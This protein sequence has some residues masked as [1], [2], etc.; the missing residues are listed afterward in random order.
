MKSEPISHNWSKLNHSSLFSSY[1]MPLLRLYIF[2][3]LACFITSALAA[4]NES[5]YEEDYYESLLIQE[6]RSFRQI[7]MQARKEK[8]VILIEFS[9][10]WCEYCEAL[11]QQVLEPLILS[12]QYHDSVIIRKLEINDYSSVI[13]FDDKKYETEEVAMQY[14]INLYPTLVFFDANGNEISHRI[15]GIR[16]LDYIGEEIDKAIEKAIGTI[17][18]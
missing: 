7:A 9:T 1:N 8:K 18:K 11:E 4:D 13:G 12:N 17:K 16:V 2:L 3:F 14:K 5:Q 15:V 6:L 10:P